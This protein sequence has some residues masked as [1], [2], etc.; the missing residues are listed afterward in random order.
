MLLA[1]IIGGSG[2]NSFLEE[3]VY[4]EY[5]P[6]KFLQDE[7]GI[8]AL[9]TGAY[10]RSRIIGYDHRN[11]T[12]MMNEFNT[13]IAFETGGGLEKDAAPFIQ[14][15]W[16]VNNSFLNSFW[17]KMYQAVASA[18]S[19]IVLTDQVTGL[20]PEKVNRVKAEARF[21]RAVSYYYLYNTFG[22]TPVVDIPV[23][24]T[25]QEIEELGKNTPRTDKTTFLNYLIAD[26]EFAAEQLPVVENPIG[27]ATRGAALAYQMKLY[28]KEKNWEQVRTIA[29]KIEALNQYQLFDDYTKLFAVDGENNKEF[30][31]RASCIAQSGHHNNYMA[32][33]FPPN[34]P[35]M[36]NWVNFGAQFRTYSAF[37]KT[38]EEDDKRRALIIRNY[39]DIAGKQVDL[40]ENKDGKELD[41]VRSFKYWPDPSGLGEA[42]G[43]DI[44]FVRYADVLLCKA[45]AINELEGPNQNC[46]DLVNAV[47][48]RASAS[49][50]AIGDFSSK[51]AF[52]DFIL[53]E[54]GREFYSEGLRREDLIRH[55]KFI[56]SAIA[57][58][59]AAK[60]HHVVFPIPLQQ[61]DAN[62][63]LEQNDGY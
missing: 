25:P 37:Y 22:P 14:F 10:A 54:R 55:G 40:L 17:Q 44:V 57:R 12:Y 33:A 39:T 36:T 43:N 1:L 56:S 23:G 42:M 53:A 48:Q 2:C 38:F 61:I 18:N 15:T 3:E 63:K 5:D 6:D 58:G 16:A 49:A 45:E 26:L 46:I 52:R 13:D 51:D 31:F 8:D 41:D 7:T 34:Y 50:V 4:T 35:I 30:I 59:H 29:S 47:R 19:V 62:P 24:A 20:D 60:N 21:I 28:L 9:L 27:R 32:H 11:Y